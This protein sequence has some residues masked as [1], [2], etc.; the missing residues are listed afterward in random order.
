MNDNNNMFDNAAQTV[1][2]YLKTGKAQLIREMTDEE[3][4]NLL[5]EF[6]NTRYFI[7]YLKYVNAR[8]GM[9]QSGMNTADPYKDPT[10]IARSQGIMM[11]LS[12]AHTAIIALADARKKQT[13]DIAAANG[14]QV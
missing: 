12:D 11:G 3:M 13:A 2:E 7:A 4:K 1:N 10:I 9:A 5:V 6:E 14:Q 8:Y